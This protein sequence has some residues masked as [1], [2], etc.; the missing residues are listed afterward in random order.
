MK[1]SKDLRTLLSL[2]KCSHMWCDEIVHRGP[3]KAQN[4]KEHVKQHLC[5]TVLSLD[6]G[7]SKTIWLEDHSALTGA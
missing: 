2:H 4:W 1:H 7:T 3:N 6:V 5:Q